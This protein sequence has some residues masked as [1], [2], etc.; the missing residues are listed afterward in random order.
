MTLS[1]NALGMWRKVIASESYRSE[2]K[3]AVVFIV[4][5][6][7]RSGTFQPLSLLK[8]IARIPG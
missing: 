4:N 2:H 8:V 6:S 7:Y 5:Y 3:K 1:H